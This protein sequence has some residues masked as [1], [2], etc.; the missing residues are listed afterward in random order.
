MRFDPPTPNSIHLTTLAGHTSTVYCEEGD[1]VNTLRRFLSNHWERVL[2]EGTPPFTTNQVKFAPLIHRLN[3]SIDAALIIEPI[4]LRDPSIQD[5]ITMMDEMN[6]GLRNVVSRRLAQF[7]TLRLMSMTL[8]QDPLI[9][10]MALLSENRTIQSLTL[11]YINETQFLQLMLNLSPAIQELSLY[12][13]TWSPMGQQLIIPYFMMDSQ[14]KSCVIRSTTPL[15][16]EYLEQLLLHLSPTIETLWLTTEDPTEEIA[17]RV[18]ILFRERPQLQ[19]MS[20]ETLD[21]LDDLMV[22][23]NECSQQLEINGSPLGQRVEAEF[24]KI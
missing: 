18:G 23:R 4:E 15:L 2:G 7:H 17:D 16:R 12:G 14:I 22:Y 19:M 8:T 10:F 6:R 11:N 24:N 1:T 5:V 20:L 3:G 9:E 13:V 21:H